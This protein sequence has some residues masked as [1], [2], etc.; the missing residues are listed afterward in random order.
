MSDLEKA[1]VVGAGLMGSEIALCFAMSGSRVALKD[2]S[3][4]LAERGIARLSTVLDRAIAKGRFEQQNKEATL[5]RIIPAD[6]WDPFEETE[7][8]VEAVFEDF[9]VK[10]EVFKNLDKVCAS[11]C[12][13]FTNTS[14]I[15]ITQLASTVKP[16][17]RPRFLGTHFFAP[18]SVMQLVE[19]IVGLETSEFAA[20]E[21]LE[22][23][24]K[25]G[26]TPI[27]VKDVPGFAVNRI[28]HAM[29]IEACRLVEEEVVSVEDC[30]IACKLGLGHPIGPYTLMDLAG[31]DLVLQVQEILYQG[32][33]ERFKPRPN[34]KQ[35][36]YAEHLGRKAGTGWLRY[37][38]A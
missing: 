25:I 4:E 14:S 12:L 20:T 9:S 38:K 36:V 16:G 21:A 7:V 6:T 33:G 5:A 37:G 26:K 27:R 8:V 19:V 13:L 3:L 24:R 23:C 10:R 30:D 15:P 35:K 32:Y 28:L 31:N 18:V 2:A 17:R 34:L 1:G 22:I 11:E 29:L